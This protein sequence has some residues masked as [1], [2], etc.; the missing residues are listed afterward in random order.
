[1]ET[2]FDNSVQTVSPSTVAMS[3]ALFTTMPKPISTSATNPTTAGDLKTI[4]FPLIEIFS[5]LLSTSSFTPENKITAVN[6]NEITTVAPTIKSK[7]ITYEFSAVAFP[8]TEKFT[9]L[10]SVFSTTP[11]NNIITDVKINEITTAAQVNQVTSPSTSVTG[12]IWRRIEQLL[13]QLSIISQTSSTVQANFTPP[14]DSPYL[15]TSLKPL[16]SSSLKE[17]INSTDNTNATM[18]AG[19]LSSEVFEFNSSSFL[20]TSSVAKAK[21]VP[22]IASALNTVASTQTNRSNTNS[23]V[24]G[25]SPGNKQSNTNDSLD[26][27]TNSVNNANLQFPITEYPVVSTLTEINNRVLDSTANTTT[28][29]NNQSNNNNLL[30]SQF[31]IYDGTN[32]LTPTVTLPYSTTTI[33][34]PQ[35]KLEADLISATS[36]TETSFTKINGTSSN[37]LLNNI[38]S[39][40]SQNSLYNISALPAQV[41]DS[42]SATRLSVTETNNSTNIFNV[43]ISPG[44]ISKQVAES[45]NNKSNGPQSVTNIFTSSNTLATL[46][47]DQTKPATIT[48]CMS[49]SF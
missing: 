39:L 5:Q 29:N 10:L 38:S 20:Q 44:I 7:T 6:I 23:S 8:L 32:L 27:T 13:A 1:M 17:L 11:V 4:N 24:N 41:N 22:P 47:D 42:P 33:S 9:Q 48:A 49:F 34:L 15:T 31:F 14:I 28:S 3:N 19:E 16:I 46:T 40:V 26:L 2:T 12:G 21:L 30:L 43:T 18:S 36:T 45:N 25:V 35:I 37:K